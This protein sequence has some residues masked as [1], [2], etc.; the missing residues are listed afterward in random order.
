M[1]T[2]ITNIMLR[3]CIIF[4]LGL[5]GK[6]V[7]AQG[8]ITR[9]TSFTTYSA[10]IKAK[11]SH[12]NITWVSEELPKKVIARKDIT[13]CNL[14]GRELKLDVFYPRKKS[15]KGYPAVVMIHG[16]GWR[17]GDRS[18]NIALG[19]QLALNGYVAVN[20]EYRLSTEAIY[21]AAVYDIKSAIR[22]SRGNAAAFKIDTSKIAVLGFSAGG[23]LAALVGTTNNEPR[24][25]YKSS[26]NASSS[27]KVQAIVDL[28]GT[29]AFIHPESGEGDDSKAKSAGSLWFGASKTEKPELWHEAGGL[30]HVSTETPPILF[31]NSSVAR[32]HAGRDDM[33]KKLNQFGIY[34]EVHTFEGAP[35][36]FPLFHP[37]FNDTV[38]FTVGFLD[39]VFKGKVR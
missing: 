38:K 29:L 19:Q 22:W 1:D 34:S 13:Y 36:V 5:I 18:Q 26:C 25:E 15:K 12:P 39:R 20:V 30:N 9:D 23:Q 17:S 4:L 3:I 37:W 35:H 6:N 11:K 14:D 33:I 24:F 7:W 27:S 32:M 8:A 10:Y 21:P 28:D 16:G 31:I 2:S